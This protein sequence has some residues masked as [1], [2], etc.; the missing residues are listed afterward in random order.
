MTYVG[1]FGRNEQATDLQFSASTEGWLSRAICRF[2]LAFGA[3]RNLSTV[4]FF[5]NADAL[6]S[7][8][9]LQD[10]GFIPLA[11][12]VQAEL[13]LNKRETAESVQSGNL[14]NLPRQLCAWLGVTYEQLA[15]MTGVSRA[16]LFNFRHSGATHRP[17]STQPVQRLYALTSLLVR[18]FGAHGARIWLHAGADPVWNY[19]IR[20]DLSGVEDRIR[21]ELFHQQAVAGRRNEITFD[22]EPLALFPA[23][24]GSQR[25]P[26]RARRQPTRRRLETE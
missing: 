25:A 26:R 9:K 19:L 20:G 13:A 5:S 7:R 10:L 17:S 18:R 24:T 6:S 12:S 16:S 15:D 21:G 14:G 8:L 11:S 4:R 1:S 22:E 3:N 2:D 23:G